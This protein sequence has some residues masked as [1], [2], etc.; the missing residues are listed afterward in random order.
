MSTNWTGR[1]VNLGPANRISPAQ[2]RLKALTPYQCMLI[3]RFNCNTV[4][5]LI[6]FLRFQ[7]RPPIVPFFRVSIEKAHSIVSEQE[8]NMQTSVDLQTNWQHFCNKCSLSFNHPSF[9]PSIY[10]VVLVRCIIIYNL[11]YDTT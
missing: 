4:A 6:G 5:G 11:A 3:S 10:I 9:F 7:S 2:G 8:R 1:L